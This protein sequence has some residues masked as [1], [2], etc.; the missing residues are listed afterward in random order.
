MRA[1]FSDLGLTEVQVEWLFTLSNR[2]CNSF[3]RGYN[4]ISM[5]LLI[6]N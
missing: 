5:T 6:K 4:G 3:I 2:G 1:E